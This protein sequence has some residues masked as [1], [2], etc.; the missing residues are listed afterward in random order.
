MGATGKKTNGIFFSMFMNTINLNGNLNEFRR[1]I[2]EYLATRT[3]LQAYQFELCVNEKQTHQMLRFAGACRLVFNRA[4]AFEQE[5][6]DVCGFRPCFTPFLGGLVSLDAKL[7]RDCSL[8]ELHQLGKSTPRHCA[9]LCKKNGVD[10]LVE[11]EDVPRPVNSLHPIPSIPSSNDEC[12][13]Q[14]GIH[15][16]WVFNILRLRSA[17]RISI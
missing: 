4:L 5:I 9:L 16:I 7:P 11:G 10:Q 3:R 8:M 1:R 15:S 13:R 2:D 14:L 12:F 17:E 6:D